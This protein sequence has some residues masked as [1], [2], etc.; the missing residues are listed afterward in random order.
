MRISKNDIKAYS[1]I[2][3]L[4]Q[5]SSKT[6]SDKIVKSMKT[7]MNFGFTLL[8]RAAT[9]DTSQLNIKDAA[10]CI[11]AMQDINAFAVKN[12][13]RP[14]FRVT[15]DT[16]SDE[17]INLIKSVVAIDVMSKSK[18]QAKAKKKKKED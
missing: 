1:D 9:A 3:N 6:D 16:V 2:V 5:K 4:I 7:I 10:K 13:M 8:E 11:R 15:N 18:D 17:A 14:I 12:K